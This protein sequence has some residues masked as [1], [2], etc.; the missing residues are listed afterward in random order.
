MNVSMWMTRDVV[1]I[2]PETP[3]AAAACRSANR[4]IRRLL[5]TTGGTQ[6]G[7]LLGIVTREDLMHAFPDDLNPRSPLAVELGPKEPVTTIMARDLKVVHPDVP[8]EDAA[9][10]MCANK[11][12][13]LPVVRS[14]VLV[15]I[16]T[17]SDIFRAF[18]EVLSAGASGVRVTFDLNAGENALPLMLELGARHDLAVAAVLTLNHGKQRLGVVRLVGGDADA[19]VDEVWRSGHLVLSVARM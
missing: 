7:R 12:G 16:I 6:D 11:I 14:G 18:R 2:A 5:V 9:E 15:G 10:V 17:E 1:T 19:F 8:I 3:I 4:R 13:A